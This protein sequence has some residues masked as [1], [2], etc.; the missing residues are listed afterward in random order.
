MD[1]EWTFGQVVALLLLF[2]PMIALIE[3]YLTGK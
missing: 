2:A 1:D 3:G